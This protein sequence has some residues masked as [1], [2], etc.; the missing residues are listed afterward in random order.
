MG[1]ANCCKKPDEIIVEELNYVSP[2]NIKGNNKINA[3]DEGG[4]PHDSERIYYS[5]IS[6]EGENVKGTQVASNQNLYEKSNSS[7]RDGAYKVPINESNYN[8]TNQNVVQNINNLRMGNEGVSL[9]GVDLNTVT[10]SQKGQINNQLLNAGP[11][12]TAKVT[13][14]MEYK[15]RVV[16]EQNV[17]PQLASV[18]MQ[19]IKNADLNNNL[20][21]NNSAQLA[22]SANAQAKRG[23]DINNALQQNAT[24]TTTTTI[25]KTGNIAT[26][27]PLSNNDDISKYFKQTNVAQK[28][29]TESQNNY[30]KQQQIAIG[31]IDMKDLP[32]VFGPSNINNFKQITTTTKTE[33]TGNAPVNLQLVKINENAVPANLR[34]NDN[35]NL[36]ETTTTSKKVIGN[37]DMKDLPEVFG[38]SDINNF[39]QTTTTTT[40]VIGNLDS[41]NLPEAFPSSDIQKFKQITT[42]TETTGKVDSKD[43]P[44][45]SDS[46]ENNFK[47]ITTTIT[48]EEILNMKDLPEVFGSSDINN[49]KKI[50]T[51][52]IE[53]T[54]N[55][56]SKDQVDKKDS[57]DNNL[58]Q[59]TTKIT[60]EEIINMKDLPEVFGSSDIQ[61]FKK[62]TTTTETTGNADLKDHPNKKDISDNNLQQTVTKITKEEIIN[63]KD[64]PEVFGS[65]DIQN[66]KKI[67]TTTTETTGIVDS[68]D[69]AGKKDVGDNNMQQ[70]TTKITKEEIINMKDLPE[71]F[72]S[73]D[74]NNFKKITTTT[75]T[76]N[77]DSKDQIGKKDS[78]DNNLQQTTTK[79][80]KEEIINMK[81]LPEVFGSSDIQNFKK[82]TTTTETTGNADLK[83]HPDKN[84]FLDNNVKQTTTITKEEIINMKDLPEVFG[85]SDINNFKK[86]TTTTTTETTGNV[87]SKDQLGI[88]ESSD[89][90]VKQTKTTVTKEEIINM[91]DL[92]EVFGSSDINNFKK[93]T[94][95]TTTETT[96]N[97][98]TTGQIPSGNDNFGQSTTFTKTKTEPIEYRAKPSE[99]QEINLGQNMTTT[100]TT[101]TTMKTTGNNVDLKEFGIEQNP[102]FNPNNENEDY[103][104]YFTQTTSKQYGFGEN[105]S[106]SSDVKQ[107][108]TTTTTTITGNAPDNLN[109]NT[110]KANENQF[111]LRQFG[112]GEN[113]N[114]SS[115]G[116]TDLNDFNFKQATTTTTT[117]TES[118]GKDQFD[119][120]QIGFEENKNGSSYGST[121]IKELNFKLD[122]QPEGSIDLNQYGITGEA[123][124]TTTTGNEDFSKYFQETKTT[125]TKTTENGP[126]DLNQFG[127]DLNSLG[128]DNTQQKTT[129]TTTTITKT[130]NIDDPSLGGGFDFKSLGLDGAATTQSVEENINAYGTEGTTTTTK[131]TKTSYV[132]PTESYNYQ[133]SYNMPNTTSSTVT[134]TTYSE[135]QQ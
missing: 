22:L 9:G 68:K 46:P 25:H 81:D 8:N 75:I 15:R 37:L 99:A 7:K 110:D 49:F 3:I 104:K 6:S 1:A 84:N 129:T 65:S 124:T 23:I 53:T 2:N 60:K 66:F 50:T 91:K 112:I 19:Q 96:G 42:T 20:V 94:T 57:T 10:A 133:F 134:K 85:S 89:N 111:D 100:T 51:T 105:P 5:N 103:N 127:V 115:Y 14:T 26:V 11:K 33:T 93:I 32:E 74:I 48:K 79:I 55:V 108:T 123:N 107:I 67:T 69:Q 95:T 12:Q 45:K 43:Q 90:N 113:Q 135:I 92:P 122:K 30:L 39:K 44:G 27:T 130:G 31:N 28:Q 18:N 101:T 54:G 76:G 116:T 40:K 77:V 21:N 16:S 121:D 47:Q 58:Q 126:V 128:L 87:D 82:I 41:K 86:I 29:P 35:K 56:D 132:G 63:M 106:S 114:G 119:L 24:T 52:T 71:V 70:T 64:L 120:K 97:V 13:K 61:N 36:K 109:L 59:T 118:T 88:N 78:T 62:I 102:S 131:V 98:D 4:F 83:D 117:T 34:L 73:S 38:S 125:T 17:S 72:G 80:T